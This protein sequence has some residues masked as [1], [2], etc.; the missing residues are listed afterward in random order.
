M[1]GG[2]EL[3][4]LPDGSGEREEDSMVNHGEDERDG[5]GEREED[6]VSSWMPAGFEGRS[7]VSRGVLSTGGVSISI[8]TPVRCASASLDGVDFEEPISAPLPALAES[9]ARYSDSSG[10]ARSRGLC[11]RV[12]L[13]CLAISL[14]WLSSLSVAR[15]IASRFVAAPTT[16]EMQNA[17]YSVMDIVRSEEKAATTCME[18]N[19]E[20]CSGSLNRTA[21]QQLQQST[22]HTKRNAE[23]V[24]DAQIEANS[25]VVQ[26]DKVLSASQALASGLQA[27]PGYTGCSKLA[28]F[29]LVSN[30]TGL[31]GVGDEKQLDKWLLSNADVSSSAYLLNE[32]HVQKQQ[33]LFADTVEGAQ[34]RAAYDDKY[35]DNKTFVIRDVRADLGNLTD[36]FTLEPELADGVANVTDKFHDLEDCLD[37][38]ETSACREAREFRQ[39]VDLKLEDLENFM[40]FMKSQFESVMEDIH[41][42]RLDV[43]AKLDDFLDLYNAMDSFASEIN[44]AIPNF[45]FVV[46][47]LACMHVWCVVCVCK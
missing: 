28:C 31:C 10:E 14:L 3:L 17:W 30:E 9:S 46:R 25:A 26:W 36:E 13:C 38:S 6:S 45:D 1:S 41:S 24:L 2:V 4:A 33:A 37:F 5:S 47:T 23:L 16:L 20:R 15:S 29:G 40:V 22:R 21:D 11:V 18:N 43:D 27:E 32:D 8:S 42:Y 44:D 19:I 7:S 39:S 35:V 12:V 34:K